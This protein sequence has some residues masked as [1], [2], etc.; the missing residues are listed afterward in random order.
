MWQ[1]FYLLPHPLEKGHFT[2]IN[3]VCTFCFFKHCKIVRKRISIGKLVNLTP[4]HCENLTNFFHFSGSAIYKS[5]NEF[6]KSWVGKFQYLIH[7]RANMDYL[8][9]EFKKR[10]LVSAF[11]AKKFNFR[12]QLHG[13]LRLYFFGKKGF[14]KSWITFAFFHL[15]L[16]DQL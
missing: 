12:L 9:V 1:H 14:R 2:L 4:A 3:Q 5:G 10:Y 15:L 11:E 6:W 16:W 13:F 8:R 7:I